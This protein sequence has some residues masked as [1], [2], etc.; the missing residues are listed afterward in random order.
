MWGIPLNPEHEEK[1]ADEEVDDEISVA[2]TTAG[3]SL[4]EKMEDVE[5]VLRFFAYRKIGESKEGLNK[6]SEFLDR[7]LVEGNKFPPEGLKEC[8]S[9]FKTT[10]DFLWAALDKKA[11]TVLGS[12]NKRPT[13]IVYDP[14]MFAANRPDVAPL[15]AKLVANKSIL[16]EELRAMYKKNQELFSGRRASAKDIQARNRCLSEAFAAAI[17]R[18]KK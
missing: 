5:L 16:R 15:R 2:S 17:A 4:F 6:I 8:R 18:I 10:I 14:L 1:D 9:M 11:F 3:L 12:S 7:F 13:K